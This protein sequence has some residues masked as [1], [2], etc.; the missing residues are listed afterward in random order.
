[1]FNVALTE[2]HKDQYRAGE[3]P[4][5][6]LMRIPHL[7]PLKITIHPDCVLVAPREWLD[8]L[9][10]K[11][12]LEEEAR[13]KPKEQRPPEEFASPGQSRQQFNAQAEHLSHE[14]FAS[15]MKDVGFKS[16]EELLKA[17]QKDGL[18]EFGETEDEFLRWLYCEARGTLKDQQGIHCEKG[19]SSY[20]Q[21]IE[22]MAHLA[23]FRN[24]N[25]IPDG[26][27]AASL[28]VAKAPPGVPLGR[29]PLDK[30]NWPSQLLSL[31]FWGASVGVFSWSALPTVIH[32]DMG[33]PLSE[34]IFALVFWAGSVVA[35]LYC[36]LQFLKRLR[37]ILVRCGH[38]VLGGL[39]TGRCADC[40]AWRKRDAEEQAKRLQDK[41][42]STSAS[43]RNTDY[44]TRGNRKWSGKKAAVPGGTPK[45]PLSESPIEERFWVAL[46]E[47]VALEDLSLIKQQHE[48]ARY[49]VD[50]AIPE[51]MLCIELDGHDFHKTKSQRTYDAQR[52]RYLLSEGWKVVRYTGSEIHRD[53]RK[54]VS[55]AMHLGGLKPKR[56][57]GGHFPGYEGGR[58]DW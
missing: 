3:D 45:S 33:T 7:W 44:G 6:Y 31:A 39:V 53:V 58:Q 19:G 30:M 9:H 52:E 27:T 40:E 20:D 38:G 50:F 57:C 49:R 32:P 2:D 25:V 29:K 21:R 26:K 46:R 28:L 24:G 35:F 5:E 34:R 37:L 22:H 1:M 47:R 8:S 23:F 11:A 13:S 51:K 48:I 43:T 14:D 54:C 41:K 17:H 16:K 18:H 12:L 10:E 36:L 15:A 55:E 56:A 4:F 42:P